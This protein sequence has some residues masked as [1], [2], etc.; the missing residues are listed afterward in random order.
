MLTP[1]KYIDKLQKIGFDE[2]QAKQ[3]ANKM[4]TFSCLIVDNYLVKKN[5]I[6]ARKQSANRAQ[7]EQN[8]V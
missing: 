5:A 8:S 1:D 2:K 6:E 4:I 3:V 7:T